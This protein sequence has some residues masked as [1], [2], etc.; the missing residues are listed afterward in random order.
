MAPTGE[1]QLLTKVEEIVQTLNLILQQS[2]ETNRLLNKL[3]EC[4]ESL[5]DE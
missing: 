4:F 2:Q 3:L 5:R 1:E